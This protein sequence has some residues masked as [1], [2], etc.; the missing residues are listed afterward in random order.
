MC[1]QTMMTAKLEICKKL[2]AN[3]IY[4]ETSIRQF[5]SQLNVINKTSGVVKTQFL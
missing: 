2:L 5:A 4:P 3:D 1:C